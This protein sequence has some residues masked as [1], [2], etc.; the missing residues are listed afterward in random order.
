[1]GHLMVTPDNAQ[2][3]ALTK[4]SVDL[5]AELHEQLGGFDYNPTGALYL[6]E[7]AED[8]EMMPVLRDQFAANGD[9]ADMLDQAQLRELEPGLAH[10]IPGALFYAGDGVVLPM[11]AAGAMLRAAQLRN[12]NVVIR[13]NCAVTGFQRDGDRIAAVV[14]EQSVIATKT[15]VNSCGV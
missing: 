2:E 10:D 9:C 6:A 11:L 1:M 5:W 12:P 8:L 13:A 3:Y 14:T 4:T 7:S 15:V